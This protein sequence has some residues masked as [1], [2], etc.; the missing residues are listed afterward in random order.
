M[1]QRPPVPSGDGPNNRLSGIELLRFAAAFTVLVAHYN[2]FYVYGTT[3]EHFSIEG[4]PLFAFLKP[5]YRYGTRA[6]EVFWC[7]SGFIFFH[8][9][10]DAIGRRLVP[11]KK[12][13]WLRFSRLYPLHLITLVAVGLLQWVYW[14]LNGRFFLVEI[15]D[16]RHFI[17]QLFFASYWG[18]QD[19][20]SYNIP[21]WSVSVE[22]LAYV[23]FFA[24]TYLFRADLFMVVAC[25]LGC[26]AI[27]HYTAEESV[28]VR[29]IFY[30]YLG[31]LSCL[32]YREIAEKAARATALVAWT[33]AA[34]LLLWSALEFWNTGDINWVLNLGVPV[35]LA[36]LAR[37]SLGMPAPFARAFDG[38]GNLTYASYL[39]H[40]PFQLLVM[41]LVGVLGI[42]HCFAASPF[43]LVSYLG[44][45]L[46]LSHF[47]YTCVE[48]PLQARIRA[49][50]I[51]PA[52]ATSPA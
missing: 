5:L 15:N 36:V 26:L 22:V 44:A 24:A 8:K 31:G 51:T 4:Q 21:V 30:F 49:R 7:L 39:L 32:G 43:F 46:V 37:A 52:S 40:F 29:C 3:Y 16:V 42:S 34:A 18:F 9:Y 27:N 17:L 11:W 1:P 2:H 41:L 47:T 33:T 13:F 23:F 12:F 28:I 50:T 45:I 6:V 10:G 20:F 19:G 35:S 38:L 48:M 25:L 14:Q